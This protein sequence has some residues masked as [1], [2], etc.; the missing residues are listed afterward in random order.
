MTELI[1][2]KWKKIDIPTPLFE[3]VK[4]VYVLCGFLSIAEY[5]RDKV[6]DAVNHD[7][8]RLQIAKEQREDD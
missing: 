2:R 7:E 4:K 6:R 1:K 8:L 5:V 3:R